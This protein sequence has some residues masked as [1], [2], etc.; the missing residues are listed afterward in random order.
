MDAGLRQGSLKPFTWLDYAALKDIG[1]DV[2]NDL[3]G[4]SPGDLTD[5]GAV[6]AADAAIMFE[7][8]GIDSPLES[9]GDINSDGM[10]DAADAGILFAA[11]TGD[12]IQSVVPEPSFGLTVI[13]VLFVAIRRPRSS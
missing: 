12:E 6:D 9:L 4:F 10:I 13:S 7:N 11:W 2:P 5:D 3:M 8:W 1:W